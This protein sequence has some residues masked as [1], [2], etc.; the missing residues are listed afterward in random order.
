VSF[1]SITLCASPQRVF[2]VVR[3]YFFIDSVRELLDIPSY[4]EDLHSLYSMTTSDVV[5]VIKQRNIDCVG[6]VARRG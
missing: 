3:V 2:L 4:T 6:H 1:A 5:T